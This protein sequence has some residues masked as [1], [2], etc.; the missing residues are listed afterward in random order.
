MAKT[1]KDK[2]DAYA[3]KQNKTNLETPDNTNPDKDFINDN[4]LDK[5]IE[6][7]FDKYLLDP[8][9]NIQGTLDKIKTG[10]MAAL[11]NDFNAYLQKEF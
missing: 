6:E 5:R 9:K 10:N 2:L 1:Q 8:E 4:A 7:E 11:Q 3:K